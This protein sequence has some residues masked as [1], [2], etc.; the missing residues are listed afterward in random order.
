MRYRAFFSRS[1]VSAGCTR[2]QLSQWFCSRLSVC[3]LSVGR[4]LAFL[5]NARRVQ[6]LVPLSLTLK[7]PL[8]RL[9]ITRYSKLMSFFDNSSGTAAIYP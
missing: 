3:L 8:H 9:R 4:T 7:L 2:Q 1:H 5:S 6:H